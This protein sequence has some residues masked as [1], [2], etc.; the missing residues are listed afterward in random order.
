MPR[1]AGEVLT[2][3][4]CLAAA[5][6][7]RVVVDALL[8]GV[9]PFVLLF[10]AALVATLV[11]GWRCGAL[12]FAVAQFWA[13]YY[14]VPPVGIAFKGEAQPANLLLIFFAGMA[15][16]AAAQ[17][18]RARTRS[19]ARERASQLAES[20]LMLRELDHR[21]KNNFQTVASLIQLQLKR[22]ADA[23]ARLALE[24]ALGR[25][26]SVSEAHRNLYVAGESLACVDMAVYLTE[27]CANL[28]DALF[29][30]ELV[31][32]EC[33]VEPGALSRDRAVAVGLI[34]NELVTNAAKHAFID[35]RPG[36]I[37]VNFGRRPDGYKLT[38]E[39]NGRG[40]PDDFASGGAGLGR[41]LVEA[42]TRQAGGELRV[43]QGPGAR[44]EVDLA[45]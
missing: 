27:L 30:G 14:V 22:T 38:V 31:R 26:L 10:P 24:E 16:V 6:V 21:M 12:T 44:F 19:D 45:A 18:F 32:L 7:L 37:R 1:W 39:D 28:A 43:G 9:A 20:D 8:P 2:A 29:L 13:W 42:F 34:V 35:G 17:A 23:P 25:V 5:A 15:V 11:G 33:S 4:I 3:L 36:E 40:L 41:G